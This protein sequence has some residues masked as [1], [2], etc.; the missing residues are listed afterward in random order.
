MRLHSIS[1]LFVVLGLVALGG[2]SAGEEG[3]GEEAGGEAEVSEGEPGAEG[4]T[5][6]PEATAEAVWA[7]LEAADYQANWTVWP[8][9]GEKYEGTEPHGALLTTYL[10]PAAAAALDA[11][12]GAMPAGAIIVKENF[13]P[14][15]MYG[16]ATVMYKAE[17]SDP[18]NH[19]WWWMKRLPDGTVEFSGS[20]GPCAGCH[21]GVAENDYIF[22]APLSASSET[23]G[24]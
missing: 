23:A 18:D 22:T 19:D 6:L 24:D 7:Y 21:S 3:A 10:N 16:A 17:G 1:S 15:G 8:G 5:A 4:Q 20:G 2:C 13:M 14:D 11:M 9:K 12:Q